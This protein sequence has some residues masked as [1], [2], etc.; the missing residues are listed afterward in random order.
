MFERTIAAIATPAGTGGIGI[1]RISGPEAKDI[2]QRVFR[3]KS[4]KS[5]KDQ[6]GYTALFGNVIFEDEVIDEAVAL[7][8][9]APKSYTGEDVVELSCHGGIA[10]MRRV[11]R[12]V[13][14]S[15]ASAAEPGEFTKRAYLNGKKDLASAEAV[16]NIINANSQRA[17]RQAN[18]ANRGQL[19]ERID[20]LR[21]RMVNM[22]AEIGAVADYPDEELDNAHIDT[23]PERLG[24]LI[25]E[26]E[27]MLAEYDTGAMIRD[28][29]E[30]VIVGRPNVGKSTLMNLLSG[31]ERS[32]VTP[33]AGTTRDVIQE[34]VMLGDIMLKISDTAGIRATDDQIEKI[35]VDLSLKKLQSAQ[36]VLAVCDAS[37][38]LDEQD[39][40]LLEMCR[41]KNGVIISNK[42][43]LP[44]AYSSDLLSDYGLP[45]AEISA[46][47]G[48][49]VENLKK[50][51]EDITGI[52]GLSP[53]TAVLQ[54]ER[55]RRGIAAALS[56]LKNAE[57]AMEDV[58]GMLLQEAAGHLEEVAGSQMS[59]RIADEIFENFCVGK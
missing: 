24:E 17:L 31:T 32:I 7:I 2:A 6:K 30:T 42:S 59:A 41:G 1:V 51:I 35:G 37:R 38:P 44:A 9:C 43:D 46:A 15:G 45:I 13:L 34:T 25:A 53:D 33:I 22:A 11:L 50:I 52:G 12:A 16:I 55:Q 14:E 21:S 29:V 49:G 27:K 10:A 54:N 4:G 47:K 40:E 20:S 19:F 28:G 3:A 48:E 56:C 5:I 23:I 8:F 57:G 18:A 36:L 39:R 26:L 58:C